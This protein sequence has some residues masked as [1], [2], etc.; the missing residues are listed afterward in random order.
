[1]SGETEG[2]VGKRHRY[3]LTINVDW[4][5]VIIQNE[6]DGMQEVPL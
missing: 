3:L 2:V 1:M 6:W 4:L 5:Q